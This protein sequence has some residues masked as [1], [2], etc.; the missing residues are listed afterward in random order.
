MITS[1]AKDFTDQVARFAD[2]LITRVVT[3]LPEPG[4]G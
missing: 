4:I 3:K 2:S 1:T